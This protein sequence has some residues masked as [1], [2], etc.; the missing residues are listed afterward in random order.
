MVVRN[1]RI[2]RINRD[3][4]VETKTLVLQRVLTAGEVVA[5][6]YSRASV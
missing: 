6:Y 3:Y 5:V 2:M 1:G 4:V